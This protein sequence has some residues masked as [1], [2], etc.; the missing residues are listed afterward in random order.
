MNNDMNINRT[1]QASLI[2]ISVIVD[3]IWKEFKNLWWLMLVI[4]SLCSTIFYFQVKVTWK[5]EYVASSTYTVDVNSAYD[6]I[7]SY[8]NQ[9]AATGLGVTLQYLM[10]SSTMQTIVAK[11]LGLETVPGEI[12]V[13]VMEGTNLITINATASDPDL[14]YRIL[15][16]VVTNYPYVAE[17]VI[18]DTVLE[19]MDET[20]VPVA[21]SN[22]ENAKGMAKRGFFVGAVLDIALLFVLAM[23]KKTIKKEEDFK[24]LLNVECYGA[25][26]LAKFKKRG[27]NNE[28]SA[29][30]IMI[31][32]F[33]IPGGFVESVRSIRT[34]LEQD[35]RK[36]G[37]QVFLVSSSI[38]GEGKSTVASNLALALQKK[39]KSVIL[40]D[41][42]LRSPAVASRLSLPEYDYGT[43]D[44][45]EGKTTLFD[46]FVSYKNTGLRVL[47]GGRAVAQTKTILNYQSLPD[48]IQQLRGM[49]DYIILDTPPCAMLSDAAVIAHHAD[50]AI[51]VVRQDYARIADIVEG[52]QNLADEEIPICGCVL[53]EAEVGITGYGYSQS[54]GYG[55]YGYGYGQKKYGYGYGGY[56]Y[57][58]ESGQV[59]IDSE[60]TDDYEME[61]SAIEEEK[62]SKEGE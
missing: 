19:V 55:R 36:N 53:N 58:S 16:S 41:L 44:V 28:A 38:A 22:P 52:V 31:D 43:I 20:G 45:L 7:S 27:K 18:G 1:D 37:Y 34:K 24:K 62:L 14:A 57:G 17:Y 25:I 23:T 35:A 5:P 39:G 3:D 59:E 42:D 49:A 21:P 56:G 48:M 40:V 8:Y 50:A 6:Y 11:D 51:F 13:S 4:V 33:R 29:S 15:Q 2:D 61:T 10:T 60:E 12:S 54:Y 26:P 30:A 46:A 9:T 32:N 47:P